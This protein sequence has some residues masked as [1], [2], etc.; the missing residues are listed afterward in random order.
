MSHTA[1]ESDRAIVLK[2]IAEKR[3]ESG[4]VEVGREHAFAQIVEH[5][6]ASR[7]TQPAERLL[8]QLGPNPHARTEHEQ[9]DTLPAVSER[10]DKEPCAAVLASLEIAHHGAGA[11]IDLRFFA[12]RGFD[13]RPCFRRR[14]VQL[15]YEA[16]D[17]L[18]TSCEGM[19][20]DQIL[21]DCFRVAALR[22]PQ[23]DQ[24]SVGLA[25]AG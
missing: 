13:H 14:P 18:V 17:A 1:R 24:L 25:S 6:H 4:I 12:W 19:A 11:V 15:A 7:P 23:L 5:H 20:V 16:L 2:Q 9:A 3:I 10:H 21:P 22:K 8:V